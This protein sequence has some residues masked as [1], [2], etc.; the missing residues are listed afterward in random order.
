MNIDEAG[1]SAECVVDDH[2]RSSD[3]GPSPDPLEQLTY[4]LLQPTGV[5]VGASATAAAAEIEQLPEDEGPVVVAL[6]GA[7]EGIKVTVV[8][9]LWRRW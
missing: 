9:C 3:A 7:G 6:D 4:Y 8:G 1:V 5:A 2:S